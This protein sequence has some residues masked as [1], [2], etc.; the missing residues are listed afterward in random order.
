MGFNIFLSGRIL[1]IYGSNLVLDHRK[2]TSE[3]KLIIYQKGV[4]PYYSF[5][6]DVYTILVHSS[7]RLCNIIF[8]FL[9]SP[10]NRVSL[11]LVVVFDKKEGPERLEKKT[12]K[13]DR[14][15]LDQL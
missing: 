7:F 4:G 11:S 1:L 10:Q 8:S 2:N 5:L 13:I 14:L 6:E 3:E 15:T 9:I 12:F